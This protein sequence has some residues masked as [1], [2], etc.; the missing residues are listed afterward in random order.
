MS[1]S[2]YIEMKGALSPYKE[3]KVALRGFTFETMYG[4]RSSSE[5]ACPE[6]KALMGCLFV[7][8]RHLN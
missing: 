4:H 2:P 8:E 1:L 6:C 5:W 7:S 3:I